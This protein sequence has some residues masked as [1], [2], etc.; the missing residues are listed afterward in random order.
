M[1]AYGTVD[2]SKAPKV[3]IDDDGVLHGWSAFEDWMGAK[4]FM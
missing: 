3:F 4:H 2:Y 1:S